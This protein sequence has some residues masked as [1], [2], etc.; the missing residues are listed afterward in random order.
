MLITNFA[1]GELSQNLNGRVDLR[2]YYQGAARIENFEIIP[3]GGIKRRPGTQR[4]ASLSGNNRIIP[5]IVDKNNVYILEFAENPNYDPQVEES[6]RALI[7]I[8]QRGVLGTYSVIQTL[9]AEYP[10]LSVM[11][12]VQYAQNY[13][14]LIL[15]HRDYKPLEIKR[16]GLG[17]FTAGN[18]DF[19]FIPEVEL[20]DDF[21]FVMLCSRGL[22][23][24]VHT[25][26]FS[27]YTIIDGV[28][29][30][31]TKKYASSISTFY[32]ISGGKLYKWDGSQWIVAIE[33]N[34]VEEQFTQSTKYP[35]CVAFFNNRLFFASTRAKP[36]MVWASAAPDSKSTRYNDFATF[37]KYVTL[38]RTTKEA[39]MHVFTFDIDPSYVSGGKTTLRNVTQDFT[40]GLQKGIT[41]YYITGAGIPV[42]TK[43]VSVTSSTM[44][45][46][47]DQIVF[48]DDE[49]IDN[50]AC[51][52]QLWRSSEVVSADDYDYIV[53]ANNITTADCSLFFELASD[54]NDAI[55]FLSSNRFLAC[56][57]ESSIWSIDPG[58][59][60]LSVN[61]VMQGRYG[62][63]SIQGQAVETATVY[64]AQ[65]NK[66]IREFYYDGESAAFRTNNIAILS[67]HILRESAVIDFDYMTNP[68]SRLLMVR[69]N[70]TMA[71]MLY[72]KTN[73]I[74]AWS[75][76]VMTNG[77]I[78]NCAVTRGDDEN[79]LIFLV[80]ED[81][82]DANENPLY[83]LELLD[84]GSE[85]YVDSWKLYNNS[86]EG[87]T[88]GAVL[89]NKT[90]G[91]TCDYDDIP[92]G[93]IT[94]GDVVYI[95]YKFTSHIK[96]MPVI[97]ND[98]SK[99]LRISALLVRFLDSF[100]PVAKITDLP[101]EKFNSIESEPYSGIAKMNYP[102]TTD[103]D[104]CFELTADGVEPVNILSVDAQTA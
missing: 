16:N 45:I 53:V 10:T 101:D 48:T 12:E 30:Y 4:L 7:K 37:K 78:R 79:D 95:G 40:Q 33:E 62:S 35:G 69:A 24:E 99:R 86:T 21:D 73:G 68:Y 72:D 56:G 1:S 23:V 75:R 15:V 36:Q 98:P 65:G 91:Q 84:L 100:K 51:T 96:S 20:D 92:T 102:G 27:Y 2:Q 47:T 64:F 67:D 13:D 89:Y 11:R 46:D 82:K 6:T 66:G 43:V 77:K 19:N 50:L 94:A 63:D 88:D 41:S 25:G 97:G 26:E 17:V 85:V 71:E 93:F 42:G 8:W 44:V 14:T 38:N 18:I 29:T 39:D 32:C 9:G 80:V 90:T 74:M 103:H 5:F 49:P 55:M 31:Y 70:G 22:P 57:T 52:I 54:Q 76:L 28:E 3:T 83:Y 61:A 58:I 60:A 34:E 59:S 81:G 104:V 87:Y